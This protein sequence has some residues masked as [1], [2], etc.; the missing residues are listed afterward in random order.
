MK[1]H[2]LSSASDDL[3]PVNLFFDVDENSKPELCDPKLVARLKAA[4]ERYKRSQA[5]RHRRQKVRKPP[6]QAR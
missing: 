3:M 4:C 2:P 6:K 1:Q 5:M